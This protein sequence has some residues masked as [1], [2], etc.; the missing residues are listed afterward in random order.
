MK[1]FLYLIIVTSLCGCVTLTTQ[2]KVNPNPPFFKE[3]KYQR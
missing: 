1:L 3:G 2:D